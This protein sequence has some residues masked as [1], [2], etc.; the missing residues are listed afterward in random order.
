[1]TPISTLGVENIEQVLQV[2]LS[3]DIRAKR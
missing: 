3:A 1:M 2:L